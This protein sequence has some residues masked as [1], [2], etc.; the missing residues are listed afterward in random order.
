MDEESAAEIGFA[1]DGD[2][3]AGFDVLGEKFGEDDLLGEEFGAD[4][5]FGFGGGWW[6][7]GRKS[8]RD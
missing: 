1:L 4:G 6:Q 7:A 2:A 8:K 3:G 5:D